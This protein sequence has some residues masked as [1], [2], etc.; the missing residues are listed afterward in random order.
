MEKRERQAGQE[1]V[2]EAGSWQNDCRMRRRWGEG[3]RPPDKRMGSAVWNGSGERRGYE[4]G[5]AACEVTGGRS[6]RLFAELAKE[7]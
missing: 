5:P 2:L 4:K 3:R 7:G 6:F 1:R